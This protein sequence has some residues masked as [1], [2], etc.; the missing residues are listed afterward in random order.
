MTI[1]EINQDDL[2]DAL[3][4]WNN[5]IKRESMIYKSLDQDSFSSKFLKSDLNIE[6]KTLLYTE[7]QIIYGFISGSIDLDKQKAY[8]STVLVDLDHRR[9]GIATVLLN[10]FEDY[11]KT[12]YP[13]IQSIDIVFFNPIHLEWIIPNTMSHIHPN[14]LG[15]DENSSGY[16]FFKHHGYIEYAKQNSYYQNILGYTYSR[17][18][19]QVFESLGEKHISVTFYDSSK[20]IGFDELFNNLN[21]ENWSVEIT[22]GIK[23]QEPILIALHH[24]K[25][26][27]F[28]GPLK[29]ESN[30]RGYFAGIG[31]HSDYRGLGI[32]KALFSVLCME[33]KNLGAHY[34]SLFTGN[35]NPA[36]NIYEKEGFNIVRSWSNMRKTI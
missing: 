1:R 16:H 34:M 4:L 21:N 9:K 8:I 19:E 33:L 17:H 22:R 2:T 36:R 11:I 10:H 6:I 28:T 29:V 24:D 7:H 30:L 31:I 20:H 35:N 3:T 12:K 18:I 27:G 5:S 15:I 23:Q 25:I 26:I 32:G 14:A 13:F